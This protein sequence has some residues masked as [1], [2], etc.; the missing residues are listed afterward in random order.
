MI[1]L[2]SLF[3]D[4]PIRRKLMLIISIALWVSMLVASV[5]FIV[6]D[7][8]NAKQQLG[9]E[10]QVL[11]QVIAERSG[12]A[13]AFGDKKAAHSNVAALEFHPSVLVACLVQP[14]ISLSNRAVLGEYYRHKSDESTADFCFQH[15]L[16]VATIQFSDE[17]LVVSQPVMLKKTKIGQLLIQV[18]LHKIHQRLWQFGLAALL[19]Q[20]M[21][22]LFAY[23]LTARLQQMITLPLQQLSTVANQITGSQDYSLRAFRKGD[24]EV[25]V[26]VTAFNGMLHTIQETHHQLQEAMLELE[27]KRAQS[28]AFARSAND[29]REEISTYFAEASHDLRQPLHAMGLFVET[30]QTIV[31]EERG[32]PLSGGDDGCSVYSQLLMQLE[33]SI[34]HLEILLTELLDASKLDA[35]VKKA[36]KTNFAIR[37]LLQRIISDFSVLADDKKLRLSSFIVDK[38]YSPENPLLLH[39][40]PLM[41]ERI[42]RNLLSNAIRYTDVGGVLVACRLVSSSEAS[43]EIW[44]TGKGI[45]EDHLQCIF[46]AHRQLDN[47]NQDTDKGF[48]LGLSVVKRLADS[49]SHSLI[50]RSQENKGTVFKI[51]VTLVPEEVPEEEVSEEVPKEEMREEDVRRSR[52]SLLKPADKGLTIECKPVIAIPSAITGKKILILDDDIQVLDSITRLLISWGG[53]V[54]KVQSY[55]ELENVL[56]GGYVPDVMLSDYNLQ[57]KESGLDAIAHLREDTGCHIPALVITGENEEA[58]ALAI[59]DRGLKLL[60][61]PVKVA[62]L[63]A[64]LEHLVS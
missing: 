58:V 53:E 22:G 49:L 25:G 28:D 12:A 6:Y 64:M 34:E 44:D 26:V 10:M 31:E 56:A 4:L 50:L 36:N 35:G 2:S 57:S 1:R 29:R 27:E 40:D 46:E 60:K 48:G 7:Q 45:A 55:P 20:L 17:Q 23:L 3:V 39:T 47:E 9:N 8:R 41:L 21:A 38:P 62:K 5:A 51:R 52:E 13:L 54:E 43:I 37:P 61:K 24:D 33:Q 32:E 30:L 11:A 15:P 63:R 18:S 14:S 16:P 19:I 59:E 42:V